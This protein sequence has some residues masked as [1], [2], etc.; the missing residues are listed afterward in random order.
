MAEI[1]VCDLCDLSP[2][3]AHRRVFRCREERGPLVRCFWIVSACFSRCSVLFRADCLSSRDYKILYCIFADFRPVNRLYFFVRENSRHCEPSGLAFGEPKDK[4]R[5][6]IPAT[7]C[8]RYLAARGFSI[9]I[10]PRG[11]FLPPALL[12]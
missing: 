12:N 5:E 2:A 8:R 10:L 3:A 1:L 9:V 6:A 11:A 4:L 7:C